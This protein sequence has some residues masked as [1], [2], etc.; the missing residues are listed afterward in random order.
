[1]RQIYTLDTRIMELKQGGQENG[2]A[3]AQ[4]TEEI[5][6]EK[7]DLEKLF[8]LDNLIRFSNS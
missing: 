2:E 7:V 6:M 3:L 1:L 5:E 8:E 4:T